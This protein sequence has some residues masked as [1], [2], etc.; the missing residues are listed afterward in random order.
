MAQFVYSN[1]LNVA[2]IIP[3]IRMKN[4]SNFQVTQQCNMESNTLQSFLQ[5]FAKA[6]CWVDPLQKQPWNYQTPA[7][8]PGLGRLAVPRDE[9]L[10]I[11]SRG[12]NDFRPLIL[13]KSL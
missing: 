8:L 11:G 4:C 6:Y 13:R 10:F 1:D 5:V 7:L 3:T 9:T 12:S 2:V